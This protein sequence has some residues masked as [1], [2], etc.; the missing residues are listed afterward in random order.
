MREVAVLFAR[1]D[2]IYKTMPGCDV[3]DIERDARLWPGGAPIVGHPPC[4]TWCGLRHMA[5]PR[6]DEK[7]LATYCVDQLRKEGGVLEHPKGS[8][9]WAAK[10]MPKP[11]ELPDAWGGFTIEV[12][13]FQWGHLCRKR[14]WLYIVGTS[15]LPPMPPARQDEPEY[16][17][18]SSKAKK[19]KRGGTQ[20]HLPK[21][22]REVTPPA[23]AQ[24]LVAL[25]RKCNP[26]QRTK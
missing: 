15:E 21:S 9:L 16:V 7:A 11:G 6:P 10:G 4:R 24:W 5:K 25:A 3:W 20:K 18:D 19:R 1:A 14:S 8:T 12:D 17:I 13:Q 26:P 2:S 22:K 23:L